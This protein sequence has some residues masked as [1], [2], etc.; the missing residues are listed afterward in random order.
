VLGSVLIVAA[1]A[2]A[3]YRYYHKKKQH[4][5]SSDELQKPLTENIE[6]SN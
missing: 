5:K 1:I 4:K 6:K 2:F 3:G